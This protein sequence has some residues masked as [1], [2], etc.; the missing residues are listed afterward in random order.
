MVGKQ[1]LGD[2]AMH[3]KRITRSAKA[4]LI[5][6]AALAV[7]V[8]SLALAQSAA[9]SG[10]VEIGEI[11]VTA[12]KRAEDVQ[13]VPISISALSAKDLE[14]RNISNLSDLSNSTPGVAI[15]SITGGTTLLIYLRGL[16]PANTAN[17]LNVDGNVGV[18]IDGIYQ[19]SRNTLD[20]ISVLDPGQIEIAKGPQSALYGRSTF[21][22]AMG[23]TTKG[24]SHDLSGALSATAGVDKDFRVKGTVSGPLAENLY[25]RLSAGYATYDGY[26]KNAASSD[27]LGGFEK[28]AIAGSLEWS[29]TDNFT[30]KLSGFFTKS[31]VEA[32]PS[33]LLSLSKFNCGTTN[34]STGLPTL[35]CGEVTTPKT[36]DMSADIPD[37]RSKN[38][39][40]ALDM[41]WDLGWASFVSVSGLTASQNE[42]YSDYDV[43]SGGVLYGVCTLGAGCLS[44]GAYTRL[45]RANLYVTSREKVR[46]VSQEFRLQS[47]D[48]SKL[49]WMFGGYYFNSMIPLAGSGLGVDST[50]LAANERYVT[51]SQLGTPA[52]SGVGAYDFTAN[53]FLSGDGSDH[54]VSGSYTKSATRT[55]S[56]FGSVGY[57]LGKLRVNAEARYNIDQKRAQT[58]SITNLTSQPYL[59]PTIDGVHVPAAGVFP[60]A[61]APY[62]KTYKNVT[63]RFSV[64][65][66][67]TPTV[68]AYATAAKGIRS[69]GFNT[70]NAVSA[71]GILAS[72]V[73]Y[74]EEE[75]WTY[76]AGFKS[77]L[78]DRRLLLNASV[79]HT[80]WSN[81]QVSSYTDNPTAVNPVRI[82][83]NAGDI[84]VDGFE[85]QTDFQATDAIQIGGSVTYSDPKFQDGAYDASS[86]TQCVT[87]TGTAATGCKVTTIKLAS[88]ATRVVPSI[89]GNRPQRAVKT[90]WNLHAVGR[91][92]VFDG[93]TAEG[94]VDVNYTGS[95]YN[96]LLNT[97][98]VGSRTL[99]NV[100]LSLAKD[101]YNV[102]LWANNL[103]DETYVAN[104]INQPR[105]GFPSV[106]SIPEIYL[107]EGRRVGVTVSATY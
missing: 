42:A 20:V 32:T 44:N 35:Y 105:S 39:Q 3:T 91:Y 25:G 73:S 69:G 79:F 82:V 48:S 70:A 45:A 101:N 61:S 89:A 83:R 85:L 64:D 72:E 84:K 10:A 62:R 90:Q 11:V 87:A 1:Q 14:A 46:T 100:R 51:V 63:P 66:Q 95:M 6:S 98:K 54:Q 2:F 104:S 28:K 65:Y 96:N 52:S 24:P 81:A 29:P 53:L 21:A 26:G 80:D 71:T 74:D 41:K 37:T 86:I 33:S 13:T 50:G 93:W 27:K 16:A 76:E 56:L 57:E 77:R 75:N 40:V 12:R 55:K 106:Y 58:F 78:L 17:D 60:V 8:P 59:Y 5:T 9:P 103:F 36:S 107:G 67:F 15:T 97:V 47:P 68:F 19:T 31:A 23:I 92:D 49:K 30:A 4:L 88:G 99:T 94:R 18:F 43:T 7:G 38:A 34:A 102:S 22:G